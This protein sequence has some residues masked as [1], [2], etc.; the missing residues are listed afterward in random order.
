MLIRVRELRSQSKSRTEIQEKLGL[1]LEFVL[2]KALEQADK[3]SLARLKEVYHRL[4]EADLAIKTGKCEGE[5]ALNILVA[6]LGQ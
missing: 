5:L 6:D 3:Y 4:L 2:R 1:T